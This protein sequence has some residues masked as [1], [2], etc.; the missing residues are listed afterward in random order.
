VKRAEDILSLAADIQDETLGLSEAA[1]RQRLEEVRG[2]YMAW[3]REYLRRLGDIVP[4]GVRWQNEFKK[5]YDGG[6]LRMR[7]SHFL[8][9]GWKIYSAYN[10]ERPNPIIPK[11]TSTYERAFREPIE[12][13]LNILAEAGIE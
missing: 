12:N 4:G 10:P 3:Y 7:A 5:E 2:L 8:R 9:H 11:W 6:W 13:Q 1:R